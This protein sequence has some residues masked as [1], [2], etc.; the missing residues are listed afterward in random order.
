MGKTAFVF[1]GQGAQ[2]VGMG[3]DFYEQIP[4]SK[5]MFE[6]ASKASGLDVAALCFE[7]NENINITEYTQIAMLAMEVA[8]L[9]AIEEL[10]G[11]GII[12]SSQEADVRFEILDENVKAV[13][14]K[15]PEIE[16]TRLFIVS[17][18]KE[19]KDLDAKEYTV[20]KVLVSVH[21]GG[22]CERCWNRFDQNLLNNLNICPRCEKAM[23]KVGF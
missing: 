11:Q 4:V 9:K 8:V 20:S 1:P 15:L 18:A 10:R 22:K 12:K 16:V 17:N 21:T 5:E 7:E 14:A 3:K 6:L 13:V 23:K 19:T 2:Y